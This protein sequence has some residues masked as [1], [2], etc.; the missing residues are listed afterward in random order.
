MTFGD[1]TFEPSQTRRI[2]VI[3]RFN[4]NIHYCYTSARVDV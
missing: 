3:G 1:S 4:Q 2:Q